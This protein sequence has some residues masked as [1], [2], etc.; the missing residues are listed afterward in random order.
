MDIRERFTRRHL[1]GG[2]GAVSLGGVMLGAC[3]QPAA[4]APSDEMTKE[5]MPKEETNKPAMAEPVEVQWL[6]NHNSRQADNVDTLV[7]EPLR[8]T[9]PASR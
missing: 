9:I 7:K 6:T 8:P 5:E 1:L 4:M 3:G 2:V